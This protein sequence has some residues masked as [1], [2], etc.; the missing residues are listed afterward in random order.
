MNDPDQPV[1]RTIMATPG[2]PAPDA[3]LFDLDGVLA[4]VAESYRACIVETAA[5]FGAVVTDAEIERTKRAGNAN[6][7]WLLTQRLLLEHGIEADLDEVTARFQQLYEG[8][9]P[10]TGYRDRESLFLESAALKRLERRFPLAIV[11]GRPRA[12][13]AYFLAHFGLES[14]F[15]CVVA[16][17]DAP[18]KPDPAGV[19]AAASGLG[20]CRPWMIGDTPDDIRAG[21]GAGAIGIG[22]CPTRDPEMMRA[23]L[24][25]GAH[26][27]LSDINQLE[28]LLP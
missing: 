6:N 3:L 9:S 11:T 16:M 13:A 7:D 2:I 8:D 25:A 27:V 14:R 4:N 17:E 12:D 15:A 21:G 19:R 20:S 10:G 1:A 5:A 22:V 18:A 24:D 26:H 28:D 23:L